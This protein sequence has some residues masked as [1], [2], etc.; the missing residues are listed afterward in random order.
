MKPTSRNQALLAELRKQKDKLATPTEAPG[1]VAS[2]PV[3]EAT[4][5]AEITAVPEP[6]PAPAEP[7]LRAPRAPKRAAA[8]PPTLPSALARQ[9]GENRWESPRLLEMLAADLPPDFPALHFAGEV[10]SARGVYRRYSRCRDGAVVRIDCARGVRLFAPLAGSAAFEGWRRH[11]E[12]HGSR[13]PAQDASRL[14][15]RDLV[16]ELESFADYRRED[17]SKVIDASAW[18]P[19]V[20]EE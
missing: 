9:V 12:R 3:A 17:W 8:A 4:P 2:P 15:C 19:V 7:V 14:C 20:P 16:A 6:A 1:E 10:I 11:F 5:A 13:D 18:V